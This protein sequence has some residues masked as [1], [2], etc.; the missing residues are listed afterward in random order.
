MNIFKKSHPCASNHN[1]LMEVL[2]D[3]W[4]PQMSLRKNTA[5][6]LDFFKSLDTNQKSLDFDAEPDTDQKKP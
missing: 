2:F 3:A 5:G 4:G 1:K 6:I